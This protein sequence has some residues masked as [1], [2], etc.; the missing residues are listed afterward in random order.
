[1]ISCHIDKE[2]WLRKCQSQGK[3]NII[4][5]HLLVE[6]KK[7]TKNINELIFRRDTDSQTL[8]N[9]WLPKGMDV[10]G[11]AWIGRLGLAYAH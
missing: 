8:K 5:H 2:I 3:I 1:M 6:S 10:V 11:G 4:C 7:K 9:E